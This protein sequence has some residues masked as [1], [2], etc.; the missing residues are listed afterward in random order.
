MNTLYNLVH[1]KWLNQQIKSHKSTDEDLFYKYLDNLSNSEFL[2]LIS[3][4]LVHIGVW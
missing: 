3:E 2:V 4:F 1:Q